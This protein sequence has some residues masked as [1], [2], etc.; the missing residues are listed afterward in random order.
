MKKNID[1]SNLESWV[2]GKDNLNP[3]QRAHAAMEFRRL[4]NQLKYNNKIEPAKAIL[5]ERL[6]Y[7]DIDPE[8]V[9]DTGLY[10]AAEG[11]VMSLIDEHGVPYKDH[12]DYA[13]MVILLKQAARLIGVPSGG[14]TGLS[15][16]Q[17]EWIE[18]YNNLL[19]Q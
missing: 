17:E 16:A 4:L 3:H 1:Y 18:N 12:Q 14:N 2:M 6:H 9:S 13:S 11:A 10:K 7:Y 8:E 5:H 19:D 15:L